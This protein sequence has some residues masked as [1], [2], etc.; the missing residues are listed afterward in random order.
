MP[1]K[2]FRK[3]ASNQKQELTVKEIKPRN[4]NQ[5]RYIENIEQKNMT[6]C[7]G[8]AGTGKSFLAC[9]YAAK[10]LIEE[11]FNK[12]ILCRPVVEAGEKIGFLPG[13]IEEKLDP[14]VRPLYDA[15]EYMVGPKVV[16]ELISDRVIEII[17]LAFMRG[18]TMYKSFVILDEAQ[19]TTPA[20]MKMFLTRLG[21]AS[22]FVINGDITQS[23]LEAKDGCGLKDA[24]STLFEIKDIG[25]TEFGIE[26]IVRHKLV[27]K[28]V[29]AYDD[30]DYGCV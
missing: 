16:K 12:I 27:Q 29:E 8:P 28:I 9:H 5:E 20:Q 7:I 6:F 3:L 17:P 13:T 21:R 18:R 15:L 26:D 25:F 4:E 10:Y 22:K 14:Y 23:D 11:K 24:W 30:P 19:N 1:N 2:K